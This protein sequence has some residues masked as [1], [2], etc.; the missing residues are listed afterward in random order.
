MDLLAQTPEHIDLRFDRNEL[1]LLN[2]ALNELCNGV[3]IE[4][5][6]FQTRLGVERREAQKLLGQIS[7]VLG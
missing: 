6:E 2:N 5:W 4:N 7:R 3:H 1:V